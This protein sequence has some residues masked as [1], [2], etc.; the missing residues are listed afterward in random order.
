MDVG[1]VTDEGGKRTTLRDGRQVLVRPIRAGDGDALVD[2]FERLSARS[3]RLR[4]GSPPNALGAKT[5]R[6]LI[7]SVDGI[8]HVAFAAFDDA[9]RLVGVARI[10]RYP[11]DPDTLDVGMVIADDYQDAGLGHVLAELLVAH[12]P[13]PASRILTAVA[14]DNTRVISLFRAFGVTPTWSGAGMVIELPG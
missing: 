7:D 9:G 8:N 1:I 12:R 2:A 5:L 13:R 6:H 3:K 4:F 10:L 14:A 11:D